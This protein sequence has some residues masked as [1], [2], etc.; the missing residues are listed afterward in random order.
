MFVTNHVLSGVVIGRALERSPAAAFVVGAGSHLVVDMIPHWGCDKAAEG[1]SE[2]FFRAARRDGL[3][4]LAV[5]AACAAAVDKKARPA[6]IAAMAGAVLLD[7]DKPFGHFLGIN[8][9]PRPLQRIHSW[10][11][12]ESVSGMRNEVAFGVAFAVIDAVAAVR[13]RGRVRA[14]SDPIARERA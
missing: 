10:A 4:G 3:L 14:L 9:I 6:V 7:L 2:R 8:P 12:N 5:M 13:S 1:Y 11:Q